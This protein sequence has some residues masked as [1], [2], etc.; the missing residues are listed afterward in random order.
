VEAAI[1]ATGQAR[2]DAAFRRTPHVPHGSVVF[3]LSTFFQGAAAQTALMWRASGHRVVAIDVLPRLDRSRLHRPQL[4]GLR[5][6]LAERENVFADL[7][8]AGV[9]VVSW[10]E[11][12]SAALREIARARR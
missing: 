2:D 3:V 12:P 4:I 8:G 11:D 9:D 6:V 5:T 7:H 1:A 10:A